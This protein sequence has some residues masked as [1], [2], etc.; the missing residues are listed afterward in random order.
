MRDVAQR[1]GLG[2]LPEFGPIVYTPDGERMVE[3]APGIRV[4]NAGDLHE[5]RSRPAARLLAVLSNDK[6]MIEEGQS[7]TGWELRTG[8]ETFTFTMPQGLSTL[9]Q[10]TE[11]K[12]G[13]LVLLVDRATFQNVSL[14]DARTGKEI[15]KL[16]DVAPEPYGLK[17]A[18][19]GPLLAFDLKNTPGEIL[20]YDSIRRI[21]RG[22][23][24]GVISAGGN[25][26]LEQR[27]AL[28]PDGRLLAAYARR[29][30]SALSPTIHVWDV[31]TGQRI[32]SLRDCKVPIWSPD[33]RH[34]ATIGRAT[35]P[36][37]SGSS[38]SGDDAN[39]KVWEV[40]APIPT[41]RQ[42]KAIAS[43]SSPADSRRLAVG[44]QL[45]EVVSHPAPRHL[46]PL[47]PLSS[48]VRLHCLCQFRCALYRAAAQNRH[49][50]GV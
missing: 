21:P 46:R 14:W 27:I 26:N 45:W 34:L 5:E 37:T 9:T 18:S 32:G 36:W 29:H 13:S 50:Q 48:P 10:T 41:Y 42:D 35:I 49:A 6:V 17:R 7:L 20:L 43:I 8:R 28:S 3:Q 24:G 1:K 2:F 40:A 15:A 25:F 47:A 22:R 33:G 39:V 38:V 12:S 19:P 44:D 23:L 31:E 30:D 4:L 11:G 16:D